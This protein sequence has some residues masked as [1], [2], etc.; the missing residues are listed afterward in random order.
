MEFQSKMNAS[1][2]QLKRFTPEE[3]IPCIFSSDSK[4]N[5]IFTKKRQYNKMIKLIPEIKRNNLFK[6]RKSE[7]NPQK[8]L[9]ISCESVLISRKISGTFYAK[10]RQK[11]MEFEGKSTRKLK[12]KQREFFTRAN[13]NTKDKYKNYLNR[14]IY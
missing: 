14:I 10:S 8:P 2:H 12:E 13:K 11:Y 4:I 6:Y 1:F 3:K 9:R 5:I 7:R